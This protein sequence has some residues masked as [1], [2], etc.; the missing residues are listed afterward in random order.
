ME[1]YLEQIHAEV[2]KF[3]QG[4]A[5]MKYNGEINRSLLRSGSTDTF[6]SLNEFYDIRITNV[7]QIEQKEY[8]ELKKSVSYVIE[9]FKS[10]VILDYQGRQFDLKP[11]ELNAL[12]KPLLEHSQ[13]ENN[14]VFG[15]ITNVDIIFISHRTEE[16]IVYKQD[17]PTGN[18]VNGE[19]S[20]KDEE[21]YNQDGSTYWVNT[22]PSCVQ[23]KPTGNREDEESRYRLEY[24]N[25]NCS[26]YWGKWIK[27]KGN[28]KPIIS[29]PSIP[30]N[31]MGCL[32]ALLSILV[33]AYLLIQLI[34]FIW[35]GAWLIIMLYGVLI[36][37]IWLLIWLVHLIGKMPLIGRSVG[38]G[39]S[40]IWNLLILFALLYGL[41]AL[42]TR[43]NWSNDENIPQ[44]VETDSSVDV[45]E[46]PVENAS[47]NLPNENDSFS[48]SS[49][50]KKIQVNLKWKGLDGKKYNGTYS[51]L[52][53]D[54]T[55]SSNHLKQLSYSSL[56]TSYGSVYQSMYNHDV[57]KMDGLYSMLDS[58]QESNEQTTTE[59]ASTIVSM[60]QSIEYTL[61]VDVSCAEARSTWASSMNLEG[62]KCEGFAPFGL[63]TPLE[64][65]CTLSG[66][67]DTRT[68]LLYTILKHYNYDVAIINSEYYAH[69]MLGVD[70]PSTHGIYKRN[71][72]KKYYFWET[73]SEGFRMGNLPRETGNINY[74]NIEIN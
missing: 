35:S 64:F 5:S 51:I 37:G 4:K 34:L 66:D 49:P 48:E 71:G 74:W 54:W 53:S 14:E 59:F 7:Q 17:Y 11:D 47:S 50:D 46:I 42:F 21:F 2:P 56:A 1:D 23:D 22:P 13:I 3:F 70:L 43:N 58:I 39:L 63:K 31:P 19:H 8:Y 38:I 32:G 33:G 72:S 60:V 36:G 26:T 44:Y 25:A 67:C 69:S 57:N 41:S 45:T 40:W 62:I 6:Y 65:L 24:Y 9:L 28:K 27:K 29:V 20:E 52:K 68:L 30:D 15:H 12:Q 61:I 73:T 10:P 16:C 18:V 55:K